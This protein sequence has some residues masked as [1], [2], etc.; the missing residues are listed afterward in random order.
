MLANYCSKISAQK[1]VLFFMMT[2]Y[3]VILVQAHNDEQIQH[4]F[5]AHGSQASKS[6]IRL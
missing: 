6:A 5:A 3:S 4:G 1:S 2:L